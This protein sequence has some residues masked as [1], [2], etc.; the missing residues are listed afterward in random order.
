MTPATL[1][2]F[3]T[4]APITSMLCVALMATQQDRQR[5]LLE[6]LSDRQERTGSEVNRLTSWADRMQAQG[7][8]E[9]R[10]R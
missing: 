4:I 5:R 9:G 8:C 2:R 3:Q 1:L 10:G 7:C 6:E